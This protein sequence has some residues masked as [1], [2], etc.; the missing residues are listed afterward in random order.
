M[1]M[2][3]GELQLNTAYL[4]P[5]YAFYPNISPK[6]SS[7]EQLLHP[8]TSSSLV[9]LQTLTRFEHLQGNLQLLSQTHASTSLLKNNKTKQNK[10]KQNKTKQ[11]NNTILLLSLSS[12]G[13]GVHYNSKELPGKDNCKKTESKTGQVEGNKG[14]SQFAEGSRRLLM[15]PQKRTGNL[16]N[17]ETEC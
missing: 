8:T 15:L 16:C 4:S 3:P 2:N 5:L 12:R 1:T 14:V 9:Y 11:N 7:Q 17:A 10:T 13:F 6:S